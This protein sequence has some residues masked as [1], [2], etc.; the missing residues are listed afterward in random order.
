MNKHFIN[1]LTTSVIILSCGTTVN[2]SSCYCMEDFLKTKNIG[3]TTQNSNTLNNSNEITIKNTDSENN[4]NKSSE[5]YQYNR[6]LLANSNND[7]LDNVL[8]IACEIGTLYQVVTK[9]SNTMISFIHDLHNM[10]KEKNIFIQ[11]KRI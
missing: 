4:S 3:N 6:N 2:S 7:K 9:C 10:L 8:N 11:K 5:I 1:F